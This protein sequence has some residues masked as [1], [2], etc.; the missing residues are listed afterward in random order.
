[1]LKDIGMPR[2]QCNERSAL[3]LLALLDLKPKMPWSHAT[4]P[5][6][7]I[8]PMMDFFREFY[9]KDYAPNSRETVR[10]QTVHQFLDAGLIVANPDQ[11]DRPTNSGKNVYQ[12]EASALELIRTYGTKQWPE[13]LKRYLVVV[14]P[15]KEK[16][17]RERAMQ[18]VPVTIAAG[19][20]I[21]LTPGGQNTLIKKIIDDFSPRFTPGGR[22]V[23]VGDTGDKWA[24]FDE[25]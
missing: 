16:Y 18:L 13:K 25:E 22:V 4:A 14:K 3:T 23:Y 20:T 5:L 24:Y 7:G 19:K 17:A 10:R 2:E 9:G 11:P 1:M 21:S 6:R 12:I 8:T 15:L